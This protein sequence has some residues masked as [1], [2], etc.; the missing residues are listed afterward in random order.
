MNEEAPVTEISHRSTVSF[1][2]ME[3]LLGR[4]GVILAPALTPTQALSSSV[5]GSE[6]AVEDGGRGQ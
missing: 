2:D 3:P 1:S 6:A 4:V 5:C